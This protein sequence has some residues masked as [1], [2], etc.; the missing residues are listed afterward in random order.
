LCGILGIRFY[1]SDAH[2]KELCHNGSCCG[3]PETE[4][5]CR[6]QFTEALKI[7]QKKGTVGFD[8]LEK[9]M[10]K[11]GLGE[12]IPYKMKSHGINLGSTSNSRI[13]KDQTVKEYIQEYWNSPRSTKSPYRYFGGILVPKEIDKNKN[14]IYRYKQPQQ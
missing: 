9:H 4:N 7:A 2:G 13:R 3:L 11:I 10:D 1:V 14:L 5:Y 6:G 8:D 12:I